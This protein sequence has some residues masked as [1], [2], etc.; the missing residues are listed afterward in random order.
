[1]TSALLAASAA[2]LALGAAVVGVAPASA[3]TANADNTATH[4]WYG[5]LGFT[6]HEV[7]SSNLFTLD[8]RFGARWG[9][10]GVEGEFGAGL[11]NHRVGNHVTGDTGLPGI[12]AGINDQQT[13]YGVGYWPLGHNIDLF[14]RLGYGRTAW[15][16]KGQARPNEDQ[17]NWNIGAGGQWFW[18]RSDGLRAEYTRENF[19]IAPNSNAWSVS[20]VRKF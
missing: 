6:G 7:F 5:M 15:N 2:A 9:Y 17:T 10:F 11:N 8:G 13:V 14:A 12:F 1:M 20:Y 3:Q 18:D 4:Y 16:F 19:N